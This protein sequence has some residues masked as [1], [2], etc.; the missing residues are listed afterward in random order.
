MSVTSRGRS[1]RVHD[2]PAEVRLAGLERILVEIAGHR[3]AL[4]A[5][6]QR[7]EAA[8]DAG[9]IDGQRAARGRPRVEK[10]RQPRPAVD[11]AR[12]AGPDQVGI[13][14]HEVAAQ[15]IE[16]VVGEGGLALGH[17][18]DLAEL[19]MLG[20]DDRP[21]TAAVQEHGQARRGEV[22][23][24][25]GQERVDRVDDHVGDGEIE[26]A[27]R[28]QERGQPGQRRRGLGEVLGHE[29]HRDQIVGPGRWLGP[30]ERRHAKARGTGERLDERT[31]ALGDVTARELPPRMLSLE[32]REEPALAAA[33]VEETTL[34]RQVGQAAQVLQLDLRA[35]DG[36]AVGAEVVEI[37]GLGG[38]QQRVVLLSVEDGDV[39]EAALVAHHV[40]AGR[41]QVDLQPAGTELRLGGERLLER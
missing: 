35:I 27:T 4:G 14:E 3:I 21:E 29:E 19:V 5:G 12:D 28:R 10:R 22:R 40:G 2:R 31:V 18:R 41:A 16:R 13:G 33:E 38:L 23:E 15:A 25:I 20:D 26:Q 34:G 17:Q 39:A 30:V 11:P 1:R 9:P 24:V 7:E 6:L 37:V 36:L 32:A 8:E